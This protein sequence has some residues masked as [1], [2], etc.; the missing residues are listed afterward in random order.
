MTT[1][2]S[3]RRSEFIRSVCWPNAWNANGLTSE[4]LTTLEQEHANCAAAATCLLPVDASRPEAYGVSFKSG[5]DQSNCNDRVEGN[6][7]GGT[8]EQDQSSDSFS[9]NFNQFQEP[10]AENLS[11]NQSSQ[12]QQQSSAI[13]TAEQSANQNQPNNQN[14]TLTESQP[15]QTQNTSMSEGQ[16]NPIRNPTAENPSQPHNNPT[17][18]Q[19]TVNLN[20]PAPIQNQGTLT[21]NEPPVQNQNQND[22]NINLAPVQNQN[23]NNQ[24]INQ[25]PV[26]TQNL[27]VQNQPA[28][29][30]NGRQQ[31]QRSN[32]NRATNSLGNYNNWNS[33][34]INHG[35]LG[36][37]NYDLAD[38]IQRQRSRSQT[39]RYQVPGRS[40]PNGNPYE[41]QTA[42]T[43]PR[44]TPVNQQHNTHNNTTVN[45]QQVPRSTPSDPQQNNPN[46]NTTVNQQPN[47]QQDR[48]EWFAAWQQVQN[49]NTVNF[50]NSLTGAVQKMADTLA[51]AFVNMGQQQRQNPNQSYSSND[52]TFIN[53]ST[54]RNRGMNATFFQASFIQANDENNLYNY[55]KGNALEIAKINKDLSLTKKSK[56]IQDADI[57]CWNRATYK[58]CLSFLWKVYHKQ[59]SKISFLSAYECAAFLYTCFDPALKE[60]IM[61]ATSL[62]C[63][64]FVTT[65]NEIN[66]ALEQDQPP[67]DRYGNSLYDATLNMNK[68]RLHV[69]PQVAQAVQADVMEI[70]LDAWDHNSGC[71]LSSYY[72]ECMDL[73]KIDADTVSFKP[74]LRE[75]ALGLK[76][77]IKS[78]ENNNQE[79][80]ASSLK[81]S[82]MVQK[83]LRRMIPDATL[84]SVLGE[85]QGCYFIAEASLLAKSVTKTATVVECDH[86]NTTEE[87]NWVSTRNDRSYSQSNNRYNDRNN[88]QTDN[89]YNDG[90][91]RYRNFNDFNRNYD[92]KY[93]SNRR[94]Q[95]FNPNVF[96]NLRRYGGE[97]QGRLSRNFEPRRVEFETSY[98]NTLIDENIVD[99]D[100]DDEFFEDLV[101][102]LAIGVEDPTEKSPGEHEINLASFDT[103]KS[104]FLHIRVNF[105]SSTSQTC[106]W[107]RGLLD[108]GSS[109]NIVK[110][111]ILRNHGLDRFVKPLER[112]VKTTGFDG[113][114][115]MIK[116][117]V[118][119]YCSFGLINRPVMFLVGPENMTQ[120]CILGDDVLELLGLKK[121]MIQ[122]L[123]KLKVSVEP[124]LGA[125]MSTQAIQVN[126]V[127]CQTDPALA[128]WTMTLPPPTDPPTDLIQQIEAKESTTE[129]ETKIKLEVNLIEEQTTVKETRTEGDVNFISSDVQESSLSNKVTNLPDNKN[130][131]SEIN[132]S[133]K[134]P[135]NVKLESDEV[136]GLES[137]IF[138]KT[139]TKMES[140]NN[141]LHKHMDN[142]KKPKQK[143]Q[144]RNQNQIE[145][146][147]FDKLLGKLDINQK[148]LLCTLINLKNNDQWNNNITLEEAGQILQSS[149][150][151]ISMEKE[152]DLK[153]Y[154]TAAED[155]VVPKGSHQEIRVVFPEGCTN[156]SWVCTP[157]KKSRLHVSERIVLASSTA[158]TALHVS[159]FS[160]EDV[161]IHK[162]Q[163]LAKAHLLNIVDLPA[164]FTEDDI[165][166]KKTLFSLK[167]LKDVLTIAET[168]YN[169][170]LVTTVREEEFVNVL[171]NGMVN[172]KKATFDDE[173]Q[174]KEIEK[175]HYDEKKKQFDE[176]IKDL[177]P[178]IKEVMEEYSDR[179][180]GD[181]EGEWRFLNARPITLPVQP[182]H[183]RQVRLNYKKRFTQQEEQVINDFIITNLSRKLIRKSNSNILSPLLIIPK[184]NNRGFRICCD[185]RAVNQRVFD[186]NSHSIPEIS[187]IILRLGSKTMFSMFDVGSAYWRCRLAEGISKEA[188]AFVMSQGEYAGIYEWNVL[189]FGPKAAVSLFSRIM[190]DALRGLKEFGCFNYLDD[191]IIASGDKSLSREE[192]VKAHA[193]DLRKFLA[194]A[195][196]TNLTFSIEKAVIAKD[197]VEVLGMF[198]GN[199]SVRAGKSTLKKLDEVIATVDISLH[200]NQLS[201]VIGFFNYSRKFIPY[202]AKGQRK[203]RKL[204]DEFDEFCKANSKKA[205]EK[206][207]LKNESEAEI[208]K[209]LKSWAETIS[210]TSL[211]VPSRDDALEVASDAAGDA[212]GW[213]CRVEATGKIIEMGSRTF[214]DTEKRY[215]IQE[216]ELLA[217]A[218]ALEKL[219]LYTHR[220]PRTKVWIDNKC[221]VSN[222]NSPNT[223]TSDRGLRFIMRIQSCPNAEFAYVR[224]KENGCADFLSRQK[225]Q[226]EPTVLA[227]K[228]DDTK[229]VEEIQTI[230]TST[231]TQTGEELRLH[232]LYQQLLELHQDRGHPCEKALIELGK[233]YF[234]GEKSLTTMSAKV[235]A[236][237]AKCIMG[238]RLGSK[239]HIG[240]LPIPNAPN[241]TIHL[242]HYSP[243][244]RDAQSNKSAVLSL[245]DSFSKFVCIFPCKG[246]SHAEI[247]GHLRTWT[248]IFGSPR[249]IRCD[250][251]LDSSQTR[252]FCE[253]YGINFSPVPV[254]R[255]ECNGVVER[256]HKDLRKLIPL[257]IDRLGLR[258]DNW[259][260]A[261]PKVAEWV[262]GHTHSVTKLPPNMIHLGHN[263]LTSDPKGQQA[264]PMWEKVRERLEAAQEKNAHPLQGPY[265]ETKLEENTP[266]WF[267]P[268]GKKKPVPA[269]V[270]KD[271]GKTA[272]IEKEDESLTRHKEVMVDKNSLSL[273]I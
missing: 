229:D 244:G 182:N 107:A 164:H 52:S 174:M 219:K 120:D 142:D 67:C 60:K 42:Q 177:D 220:A 48:P 156:R 261:L 253:S 84:E 200:V 192:T 111:S 173:K 215:T 186:Y 163:R 140:K 134:V 44:S 2:Y 114:S 184:P 247:L 34:L 148:R 12:N 258:S 159:N 178:E 113:S 32:Q 22:Q 27:N 69:Y 158:E 199:G 143:K 136:S 64:G 222:I 94:N 202:F 175:K 147:L 87:V 30:Q 223:C 97:Y 191:C 196:A 214:T 16:S 146:A 61:R 221:A 39:T 170:E 165:H 124:S 162:G 46:N 33:N 206:D 190:D 270:T 127:S 23:L 181:A 176:L 37:I 271:H 237:C 251:A 40:Y 273:R 225:E 11:Q 203:I 255:P 166:R 38:R 193:A 249:L 49:E 133:K 267:W 210:N 57:P 226:S 263:T 51:G 29:H 242:D 205:T 268:E 85:I 257:A 227:V 155:T 138:S 104:G 224:S 13:T 238:R 145:S 31:E 108:S 53:R 89:R 204:K 54:D 116:E 43:A 243:S 137:E 264:W 68:L 8:N 179:F 25:P 208:K 112:P 4:N 88:R 3:Q 47:N 123:Y 83:L 246:Y 161:K 228:T 36:S 121:A 118:R 99:E 20:Q 233:L 26:R 235:L 207:K 152:S 96:S 218:E 93:R 41:T 248:M 151:P 150:S 189:P 201:S 171:A 1:N 21:I 59:V 231:A 119:I 19:S 106:K 103:R 75:L 149:T 115:A 232:K 154:V 18:I 95:G 236:T 90:P 240:R 9:D 7:N 209:I 180:T 160:E 6:N 252:N 45:H 130:N 128:E 132:S 213:V 82:Q 10:D 183:P 197:A 117:K 144:R 72:K 135:S 28:T 14:I 109:A 5:Y 195:R 78:L 169:E 250:N 126:E 260:N 98:V 262:N 139:N 73:V 230:A 79:E 217:C 245:R 188:T 74:S 272:E 66:S 256:V 77:M 76:N 122:Q 185:F 212:L 265:K 81:L 50:Q 239:N 110:A 241:Q 216:R 101:D 91:R 65:E 63:V 55:V 86:I 131:I 15:I 157:F 71:D 269:L 129:K 70:E 35:T 234:P 56:A 100:I 62:A 198:L 141:T 167:E 266:V 58:S 172:I 187:D 254:Y 24:N 105:N 80:V 259:C 102:A 211:A 125:Q 194:R 153:I 92:N 17:E 168:A